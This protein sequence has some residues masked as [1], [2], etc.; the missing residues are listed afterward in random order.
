MSTVAVKATKFLSVGSFLNGDAGRY[1][2]RPSNLN[3]AV[4]FFLLLV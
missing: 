3:Y 2:Y 4:D 1:R